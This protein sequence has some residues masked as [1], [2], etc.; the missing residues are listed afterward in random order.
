MDTGKPRTVTLRISSD[1]S[2]GKNALWICLNDGKVRFYYVGN[3]SQFRQ[4]S[5]SLRN[6]NISLLE[7]AASWLIFL[8]ETGALTDKET[9][10]GLRNICT[11]KPAASN[12]RF[13]WRVSPPWNACV[14]VENGNYIR[15]YRDLYI[16]RWTLL[17][18][19]SPHKP[20]YEG[21][22]LEMRHNY[23]WQ[24]QGSK[25]SL[26]GFAISALPRLQLLNN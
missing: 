7:R 17:A 18:I 12:Q 20:L 3:Y 15:I 10:Y 5:V 24:T 21:L 25:K 13:K 22:T 4:V 6:L 11:V 26:P 16:V 14:Q 23:I 19:Q 8:C 1:F 2:K 9:D